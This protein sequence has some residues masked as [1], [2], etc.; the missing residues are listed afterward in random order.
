MSAPD[1]V[2]PDLAAA[3]THQEIAALNSRKVALKAGHTSYLA[4]HPEVKNMLNDFLSQ[5]LLS[6][7]DDVFSFAADHFAE[8]SPADAEVV[9]K[10]GYCPVVVCGPMGVGKGTLLNLLM[11]AFPGRF[12]R[13]VSHTTRPMRPGEVDGEDYHFTTRDKMQQEIEDGKFI[14]FMD[15]RGHL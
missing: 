9:G 4:S 15:V 1:P 2:Q 13:S 5:V 10:A 11:K 7:P 8:L 14:E 12:A 6:R 3:L